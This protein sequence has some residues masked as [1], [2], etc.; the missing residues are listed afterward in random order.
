MHTADGPAE[1]LVD[2]SGKFH[3]VL[4]S[5]ADGSYR[6]VFFFSFDQMQQALQG[7]LECQGFSDRAS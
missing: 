4:I 7:I 2:K 3:G 1:K 5:F 6:R